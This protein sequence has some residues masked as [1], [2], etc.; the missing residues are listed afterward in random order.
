MALRDEATRQANIQKTRDLRSRV[1][2]EQA[3][4]RLLR[5]EERKK[6]TAE[7]QLS[8]LDLRLGKGRGARKERA[9]LQKMLEN[10]I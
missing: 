8:L 9:R 5:A 4:A 10:N 1:Q 3:A 6:R 2:D 7:Q